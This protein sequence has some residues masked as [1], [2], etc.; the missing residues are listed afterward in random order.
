M[1]PLV[2]F[3]KMLLFKYLA[4]IMLHN[5]ATS[6]YESHEAKLEVQNPQ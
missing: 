1:Q 5:V 6:I 3:R 4:Y 2:T